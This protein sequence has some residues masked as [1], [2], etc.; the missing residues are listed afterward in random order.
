M[1]GDTVSGIIDNGV[2]AGV[3]SLW[4]GDPNN[5][6]DGYTLANGLKGTPKLQASNITDVDANESYW[7][8]RNFAGESPFS[9]NPSSGGLITLDSDFM[10]AENTGALVTGT[11]GAYVNQALDFST[12]TTGQFY[13]EMLLETFAGG[14]LPAVGIAPYGYDL[15]AGS[16]IP[17]AIGAHFY[18]YT[19]NGAAVKNGAT[20]A[21]DAGFVD[22]TRVSFLLDRDAGTLYVMQNGDTGG[23]RS[24]T[25]TGL[26]MS[27]TY[28]PVIQLTSASLTKVTAFMTSDSWIYDGG[29]SYSEWKA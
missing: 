20:F 11:D 24:S 17:A 25:I 5:L 14:S 16:G 9:W 22:P 8:M 2:P 26:D 28:Q 29:A 12:I 10:T 1:R 19:T 27:L 13:F 23:I 18:G 6:P 3:L 15:S 7:I 21:S 4:Y